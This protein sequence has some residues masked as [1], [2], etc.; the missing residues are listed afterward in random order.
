MASFTS[1]LAGWA[2]GRLGGEKS[3][4]K[5]MEFVDKTGVGKALGFLGDAALLGGAGRLAGMG[6]KAVGAKL[7]MGAAKTVDPML[8]LAQARERLGPVMPISDAARNDALKAALEGAQGGIG[9]NIERATAGLRNLP[10]MEQFGGAVRQAPGFGGRMSE[11]VRQ[12]ATDYIGRNPTMMERLGGAVRGIPGM[13]R[14]AGQT[15]MEKPEIAAAGLGAYT[16]ARQGTLNRNIQ[17]EQLAQRER[18]FEQ[19]FGQSEAERKR[20]I[21]RQ[22]RIAQMLA[23]L[24]QRIAGGQG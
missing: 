10:G 23:P 8:G 14:R 15:L 22:Q 11:M 6:A 18:E 13:A 2:A 24:F 3:R 12:G 9:A 5:T 19:T 1:R 17:R 16:T 20:E 7:G 4:K 21:E